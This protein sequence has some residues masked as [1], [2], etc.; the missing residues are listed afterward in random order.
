MPMSL[1]MIAS[2]RKQAKYFQNITLNETSRRTQPI[3]S[4]SS[5][6]FPCSLED[7]YNHANLQRI[8]NLLYI[9]ITFLQCYAIDFLI[10]S[11]NLI[12][13]YGTSQYI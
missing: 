13:E 8:F 4:D 10:T 5:H 1:N 11:W 9:S 12:K 7:L 3:I 2:V 6:V